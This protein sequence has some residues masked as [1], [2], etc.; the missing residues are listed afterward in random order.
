MKNEH[1]FHK[2]ETIGY[3][4][5]VLSQVC[6]EFQKTHNTDTHIMFTVRKH[7]SIGHGST[8][9]SSLLSMVFV[10]FSI[11]FFLCILLH[12][13]FYH[14][15][16]DTACIKHIIVTRNLPLIKR[17]HW[18]SSNNTYFFIYTESNTREQLSLYHTL[19]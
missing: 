10:L 7:K 2:L 9:L 16:D 6:F 13:I 1:R 18:Y 14:L 15:T 19:I 12:F 4:S 3:H 8:I 17:A 11:H 5:I